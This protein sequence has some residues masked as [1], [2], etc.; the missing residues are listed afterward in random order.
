MSHSQPVSPQSPDDK[1]HSRWPRL[2]RW[3]DPY[4]QWNWAWNIDAA[5]RYGAVISRIQPADLT[6][7]PLRVCDVGCGTRGG[8]SGYMPLPVVGVDI[9]FAPHIVRQFPLCA[10]VIASGDALPLPSGAFDLVVCMDVL[11]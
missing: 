9:T 3:L 11:E 7:R 5:V 4:V 2:R 8:F 6:G 1:G 10:P